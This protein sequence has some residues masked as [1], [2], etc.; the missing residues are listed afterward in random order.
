MPY[1]VRFSRPV[2]LQNRYTGKPMEVTAACI[3]ANYDIKSQALRDA[4]VQKRAAEFGPVKE[5]LPL[6]YG[7]SPSLDKPS[8]GD[9]CTSPERCAGHSSCPKSYACSE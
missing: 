4:D 8:P 3:H 9:F 7:A 6:P 2:T 1:W 5:I